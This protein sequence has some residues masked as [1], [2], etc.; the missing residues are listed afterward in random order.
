VRFLQNK[1]MNTMEY[2][3]HETAVPDEARRVIQGDKRFGA[4]R[5]ATASQP[6]S[7]SLEPEA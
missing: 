3:A 2:S 6:N 5:M 4:C 7:Q 1:E